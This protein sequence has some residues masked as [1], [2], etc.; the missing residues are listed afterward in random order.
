[1]RNFSTAFDGNEKAIVYNCYF[2]RALFFDFSRLFEKCHRNIAPIALFSCEALS[3]ELSV[4]SMVFP[5]WRSV[6]VSLFPVELCKQ[7]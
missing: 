6:A 2:L 4:F 3:N 1:M 5:L 7:H